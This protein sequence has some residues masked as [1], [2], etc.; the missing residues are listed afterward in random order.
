MRS[1]IEKLY[2]TADTQKQQNA[3]RSER[4]RGGCEGRVADFAIVY[5]APNCAPIVVV[6]VVAGL[7]AVLLVLPVPVVQGAHLKQSSIR[8][9][10]FLPTGKMFKLTNNI[11]Y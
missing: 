3:E 11:M 5:T 1:K 9:T 6:L 10:E 2:I 4:S 7:V 8:K